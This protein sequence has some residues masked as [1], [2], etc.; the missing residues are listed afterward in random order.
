M[1]IAANLT[2]MRLLSFY[3]VSLKRLS[4]LPMAFVC[5]FYVWNIRGLNDL[6][7]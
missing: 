7:F 2:G 5:P 1:L 6:I 3:P 4:C